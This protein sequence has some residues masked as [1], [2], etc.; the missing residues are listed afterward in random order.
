MAT[1]D[2]TVLLLK[3]MEMQSAVR[4]D[5]SEIHSMPLKTELSPFSCIEKPFRE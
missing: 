1:S 2:K 5:P 3:G 4:T